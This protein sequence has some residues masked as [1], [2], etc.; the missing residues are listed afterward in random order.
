[1][2]P[3]MLLAIDV[4]NTN[5]A[6]AVFDELELV[7]QW[8]CSTEDTRTGDE[9]FVWLS[10][11]M[12]I[13]N[14]EKSIDKVVVSCVVPNALFNIK[15]LCR[16]YFSIEPLIVG[17]AGCRLPVEVRVDEGVH[18]GADRLVNTVAAHS[19]YGGNL[20]VVDFGTAT[21]FDVVDDDGA[22]VG[23]AIA[24]GVE[25]S[26]NVLHKAA[27]ALPRVEV[28]LPAK[29]IGTNTREC[30]HSGVF[31]GYAGLIEGICRKIAEERDRPMKVVGTGG[32][33]V[34]FSKG[35]DA[36]DEINPGLTMYGLAVI[37]EYNQV[38]V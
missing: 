35:L 4:G 24:P 8:R 27:A 36:F 25:L 21:T 34:L 7:D 16:R 2:R 18:V 32:L 3:H 15:I 38:Q 11:L 14:L 1:M 13:R 20:I 30:M 26:L 29:A 31:W 5:T 28:T 12:R 19:L 10:S 9:Y 37:N 22:Y 6:F 17:A 23:G 33:S